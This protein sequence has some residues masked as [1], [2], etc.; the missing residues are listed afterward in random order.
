MAAESISTYQNTI[1]ELINLLE[2]IQVVYK[3]GPFPAVEEARSLIVM[4][5]R[6]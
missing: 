6:G 5:G 1:K 4:E 2:T 3:A